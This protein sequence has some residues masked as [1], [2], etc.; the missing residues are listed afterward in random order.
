MLYRDVG[1]LV[2]IALQVLFF[3]TP[4]TYTLDLVPEE[5]HGIPLRRIFELNPMTQFVNVSRDL[6]YFGQRPVARHRGRTSRSLSIV[7]V[8]GGWAIFSRKAR[9]VVEEL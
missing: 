2:S 5:V 7:V 9:S 3:L 6:F 8:L 1:Y 4:I